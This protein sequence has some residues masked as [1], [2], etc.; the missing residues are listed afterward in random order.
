MEID[1]KAH[2][3]LAVE[4]GG[5]PDARHFLQQALQPGA[6]V[7]LSGRPMAALAA[8]AGV[9]WCDLTSLQPPPPGFKR[10]SCLSLPSSWDYRHVP[11]YP[12]KSVFLVETG[13]LHIGQAGLELLTSDDPPASASPVA[14][15]TS[16][17]SH[18][19]TQAGVQWCNL[20]SLEPVLPGF[21]FLSSWD[22]RHERECLA[23]LPNACETIPTIFVW[24]AVTK[25]HRL[26]GLQQWHLVFYSSGGWMSEIRV[27]PNII[28]LGVRSIKHI[29][30]GG[31]ILPIVPTFSLKWERTEALC[32]TRPSFV[33]FLRW[34]VALLPRLECNGTISAHCNLCLLGSSLLRS[35]DYR[36][37]PP[38][39]A[40]FCIFSRDGVS[41]RCPGWFQTPDFSYTIA[42]A[43]TIAMLLGVALCCSL[44]T[45]LLSQ[46]LQTGHGGFMGCAPF[47]QNQQNHQVPDVRHVLRRE[48]LRSKAPALTCWAMARMRQY[49]ASALGE[50]E[51]AATRTWQPSPLK[52]SVPLWKQ[53]SRVTRRQAGVQ[54]RDLGSLQLPPPGFKQFSCLSL[55]SSWDYR[56]TP[57][58]PANFFIKKK[59]FETESCSV[60]QAGVQWR[61]LSSLQPPSPG[62]KPF[63]SLGLLSTG[64]TGLRHHIR[65]IFVFL[66]E[67]GF[68]HVVQAG[69][70]L[71]TSG[72]LPTSTR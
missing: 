61:D 32:S 17:K 10:F 4:V 6:G 25:Y 29:N 24:A 64:I 56:C 51:G 13:F 71:L 3:R 28:T 50:E 59:V 38:C 47:L 69:L 68:H 20:S 15:I 45:F 9:Q 70:E 55:L 1:V 53:P 31:H 58:C 44:T 33:L 39:P 72:D 2:G 63:S 19:A 42:A 60:T 57:P 26:G 62:L 12:A 65:L 43:A 21:N 30:V 11:P 34:S 52:L 36:H 16:M 54:W 14:G 22:Y 41:P 48:P 46:L 37:T 18:S 49:S 7:K 67:M 8:Q 23:Q 5:T 27:L 40:N 66:V 35:W